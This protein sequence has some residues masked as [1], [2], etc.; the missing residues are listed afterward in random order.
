MLEMI[1]EYPRLVVLLGFLLINWIAAFILWSAH[2]RS[3]AVMSLKDATYKAIILGIATT[4]GIYLWAELRVD[5]HILPR[6]WVL[7]GWF[8]VLVGTSAPS[9]VFVYKFLKGEF[10]RK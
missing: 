5:F 1:A 2:R 8:L 3:P 10:G 7:W 4:I 9:L 6:E